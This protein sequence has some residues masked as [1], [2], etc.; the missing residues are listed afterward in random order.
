[1]TANAW[2]D[3]FGDPSAWGDSFDD[4]APQNDAVTGQGSQSSTA[5]GGVLL[6]PLGGEYE[7]EQQPQPLQQMQPARYFPARRKEYVDGEAMCAQ[8]GQTSSATGDTKDNA[9]EQMHV[10][11]LEVV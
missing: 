11:L 10:M 2:G 3:A 1:V 6:L 9:L 5:S 7:A 8:A 4:E